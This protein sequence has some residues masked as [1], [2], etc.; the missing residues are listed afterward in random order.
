MEVRVDNRIVGLVIGDWH[1]VLRGED[2]GEAIEQLEVE[3]QLEVQ[4]PVSGT[5]GLLRRRMKPSVLVVVDVGFSFRVSKGEGSFGVCT[6]R[7]IFC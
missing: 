5:P 7:I 3:G 6:R 1:L 4:V 2:I